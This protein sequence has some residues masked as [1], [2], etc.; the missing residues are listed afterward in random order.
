MIEYERYSPGLCR[1][2]RKF[3]MRLWRQQSHVEAQ[4]ANEV[5]DKIHSVWAEREKAKKN[6]SPG[7][8]GGIRSL[9]I[10]STLGNGASGLL[11][12]ADALGLDRLIATATFTVEVEAATTSKSSP[13]AKS[14]RGRSSFPMNHTG[15]RT[16]SPK[17]KQTTEN[18]AT[19]SNAST[20]TATDTTHASISS[21]TTTTAPSLSGVR[22]TD[23]S[24]AGQQMREAGAANW[25]EN[26]PFFKVGCGYKHCW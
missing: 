3:F 19:L 13:R 5:R 14:P 12:F 8:T 24:K 25:M 23:D 16:K 26:D 17:H 4:N 6:S 2:S 21:T 22:S 18:T 9:T 7:S 11:T 1:R 20:A 15:S 10:D